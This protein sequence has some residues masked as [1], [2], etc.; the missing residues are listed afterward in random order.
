MLK[1]L[2]VK[3]PSSRWQWL[4]HIN[5]KTDCFLVSDLKTKVSI[6]SSLLEQK[7]DLPG[8][9]VM[10]AY[11]FYKELVSSLCLPWNLV[12]DFFVKEL[13][14]EFC[15]QQKE[16]WRQNLHNSQ[17]FLAFFNSF[18]PLL[19]HGES[20]RLIEEWL[21]AK[22]KSALWKS[23][24]SLSQDFFLLLKKRQLLP[25]SGKKAL[26]LHHLPLA[27]ELNF[28]KERIYVD[29]S[30]SID[31]CEAEI[32]KALS[33]HKEIVIL[34]P[35]LEKSLLLD[36]SFEVYQ[37]L[38]E[39]L[40]FKSLEESKSKPPS[41]GEKALNLPLNPNLNQTEVEKPPL[42]DKNRGQVELE[43]DQLT[44]S[45]NNFQ[46]QR[47][48]EGPAEFETGQLTQSKNHFQGERTFK[49]RSETQLE[50]LKK[51]VFQVCTWLK[52]GI[53]PKDMALFA[54]NM[55][56]H[57]FALKMYLY[58]E[59]IPVAKSIFAKILDYREV[60]YFL[61]A[62][63]LHISSF[64]FEDLE[65]FSFFRDSQKDFDRFKANY[66]QIPDRELSKK[67]LF[68]K[69][70]LSASKVLTG[71]Q[72]ADWALSF[73]PKESPSFLWE[74]LSQIFLHLP[75][76]ESL[77]A[78]SWLKILESE[79][80][81][82]EWELK[83]EDP[84]GIS[85]LSFNAFSSSKSPYVYILDLS[86]TSLSKSTS[87]FL[88]D[89]EKKEILE[90][91]G[92]PLAFSHPQEKINNLLWFLQSSQH[93]EV[94][95][96]FASYD[97]KGAV[98]TPSLLY[99]LSEEL[100]S[101]KEQE[102]KGDLSWSASKKRR[103]FE[104]DSMDGLKPIEKGPFKEL[105]HKGVSSKAKSASHPMVSKSFKGNP[106]EKSASKVKSASSRETEPFKGNPQEDL[107]VPAQSVGFIKAEHFKA[108]QSAFQDKRTPFFH[109]EQIQLSPSRLKT[110]TDCPFKYSAEK[111]FFV[112]EKGDVDWELSPLSKGSMIHK[113]FELT[114]KKHPHL[115]LSEEEIESLLESIKPK[116]E[117]LVYEQQ[118]P[119]LK[120]ELKQLL[121]AFLKKERFDQLAFPFLKAKFFEKELSA[122]WNQKK[123]ELDKKG[124]YPFTA[125]VDRID[126]DEETGAYVIRD[127]KAS[128]QSLR[129]ISTWT[130]EG[131]EDLQLTFYTQALQKGLLLDLPAGPVVSV[132]YSSY[133]E[134]FSA[135]GFVDKDSSLEN[136]LGEKARG[137]K[138]EK[139]VLDQALFLSNQV[140]K[141]IVR[142]MEKGEFLPQP[143]EKKLCKTCFCR[144]WCRVESLE[145][146]ET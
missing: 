138:K 92:F 74:K 84:E 90:E 33:L 123:G 35:H 14:S 24:I 79:L 80:Q 19:W 133:K 136:F 98:Q 43:T 120:E 12:S 59:N 34:S 141:Q 51:A 46:G 76:T 104:L 8:L 31:L 125:K 54:P 52:K 5:P 64:S 97:L 93:K 124:E 70:I 45:K 130:K 103:I 134:D 65:S 16:K 50:E 128:V 131:R 32:F 112:R 94:Y 10:R 17:S 119:L 61:S 87:S 20:P 23:W 95:L 73:W 68:Q 129:H 111:L 132:F 6:E 36:Q 55:E 62:L 107:A 15:F 4:S 106:Q 121:K 26:L 56:D 9:C 101:A 39:E 72:F 37:L 71:S 21:K 102:I 142:K 1:I 58:K 60:R 83:I 117:E 116:E 126:Q 109:T 25:E 66:F 69:K 47:A 140:L 135:K 18:L 96:S 57:W 139:Q 2:K 100:F 86:S 53:P 22:Q 3:D 146:K 88:N 118:W 113:L 144:A 108:V 82:L 49:V 13:F 63:R 48:F 110:Y 145:A 91:L 143:K 42:Q 75:M 7:G 11:E 127:Y 85:C 41:K 27:R 81:S 38:E 89:Q 115:Q 114:L 28:K 78:S 77:K 67:F 44:Q 29:L 99:F 40:G 137:P 30:F 105:P 122:F